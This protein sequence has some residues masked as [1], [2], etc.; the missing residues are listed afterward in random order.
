M[1]NFLVNYIFVMKSWDISILGIFGIG[2][3][4]KKPTRYS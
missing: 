1:V 2:D 4:N 3:K